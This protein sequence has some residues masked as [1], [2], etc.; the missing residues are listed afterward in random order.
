[1]GSLWLTLGAMTGVRQESLVPT[2]WP[3]G[4][5]RLVGSAALHSAAQRDDLP[6][7]GIPVL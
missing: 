7:G 1:L 4:F 2:S 5:M 6:E 3:K